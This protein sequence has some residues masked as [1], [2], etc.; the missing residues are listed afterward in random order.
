MGCASLSEYNKGCR[1]GVHAVGVS[2]KDGNPL[3]DNLDNIYKNQK[4]KK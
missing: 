2:E 3:C 4:G 1:A